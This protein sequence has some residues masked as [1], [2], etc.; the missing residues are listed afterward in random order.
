MAGNPFVTSNLNPSS[1]QPVTPSDTVLQPGGFKVLRIG[2]AGNL[3]LKGLDGISSGVM[4][5]T[6]GE[7]VPFGAGYVMATGTTATGIVAMG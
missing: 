3:V 6:A 7:Y 2:V 5:V 4:A 1:F